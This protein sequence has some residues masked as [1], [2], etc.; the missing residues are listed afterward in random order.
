MFQTFE[1]YI[2]MTTV[3]MDFNLFLNPE[4]SPFVQQHC[5]KTSTVFPCLITILIMMTRNNNIFRD[6]I[7]VLSKSLIKYLITRKLGKNS[8]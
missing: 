8:E 7:S 4:L 5:V 1:D 6:V 3:S 2:L